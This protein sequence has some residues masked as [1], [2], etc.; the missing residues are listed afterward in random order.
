M[1]M[2]ASSLKPPHV[3]G[4]LLATTGAVSSRAIK[5][6]LRFG[7]SSLPSTVLRD[8]CSVGLYVDAAESSIRP[9]RVRGQSE[10]KSHAGVCSGLKAAL[11]SLGRA[12]LPIAWAGC[13]QG[14]RGGACPRLCGPGG[15]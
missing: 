15:C 5:T 6:K 11:C 4:V 3:L 9:L 2:A 1:R 7:S 10:S 8:G 13:R 14:G 12:E